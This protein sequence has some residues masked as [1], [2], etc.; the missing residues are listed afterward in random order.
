MPAHDQLAFGFAAP[1]AE[2]PPPAAPAAAA[3]TDAAP[4]PAAPA[5]NRL[6]ME[7]DGGAR[8]NP[9]PAAIG[10]V[11]RD[12]DTN[13]VVVTVSEY[14]GETT[15]NVAEYRALIE[16]LTR[17]EPLGAAEVE[18]RAD[19]LRVINQ[20]KGLWKVKQAHLIPL[21]REAKTLLSRYRRTHLQHIPREENTAADALVNRALDARKEKRRPGGAR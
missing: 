15:N 20:L 6:V 11:V 1:A 16:A 7:C 17:S 10:A 2:P 13:E 3:R 21:H 18:V 9:G 19:S 4:E 14:I 12:C 8:G 5:I